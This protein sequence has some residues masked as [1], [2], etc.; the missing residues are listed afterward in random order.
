MSNSS[1][2]LKERSLVEAAL[3]FAN[4]RSIESNR[5]VEDLF[6]IETGRIEE[7][8]QFY[9]DTAQPALRRWLRQAVS[10]NA[11]RAQTAA[12]I[13][14]L[15]PRDIAAAPVFSEDRLSYEFRLPGVEAGC[16]LAV[17]LVLDRE[18]ALAGRLQQCTLSWC[19]RFNVDFD[20]HARPRPRKYCSANHRMLANYEQSPERMRQ[21]RKA[22]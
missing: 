7:R 9:R 21:W 19:G 22:A 16:V 2:S 1:L 18:R 20:G 8:F 13:G 11:G 4:L 5:Q 10:G 14:H 3:A 6:G 12:E 17:A 15:M